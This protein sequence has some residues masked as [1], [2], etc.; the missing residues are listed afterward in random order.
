MAS[1]VEVAKTTKNKQ[2]TAISKPATKDDDANAEN[3]R[4]GVDAS[5]PAGIGSSRILLTEAEN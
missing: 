1:D 4:K 5:C 2:A 3:E